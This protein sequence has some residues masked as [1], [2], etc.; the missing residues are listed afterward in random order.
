MSAFTRRGATASLHEHA[1]LRAA[2]NHERRALEELLRRYEPLIA[3][4]HGRGFEVAIETNGTIPAPQG[5]DW[6]CVS[7]KANGALRLRSGDELKLIYP[8]PGAEPE[9]FEQLDFRY[10]SLQ[11][12]DGP[13]RIANTRRAVEYCLAHPRWRVSLQTHKILGIP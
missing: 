1:L 2:Q 8:Q 6:I 11:P 12:M 5:I 4:M 13:E 9:K 10:F 7:P 3:A